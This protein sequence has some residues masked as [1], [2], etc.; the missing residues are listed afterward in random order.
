MGEKKVSRNKCEER[1]P[2]LLYSVDCTGTG[3]GFQVSRQ[4]TEKLTG[5][6]S[7]E[8]AGQKTEPSRPRSDQRPR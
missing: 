7:G 2:Q 3:L 6:K 8:G 4:K 5:F 1:R